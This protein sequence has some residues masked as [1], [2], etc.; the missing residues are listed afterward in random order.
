M[1]RKGKTVAPL[2]DGP[3]GKIMDLLGLFIGG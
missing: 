1:E 2:I 3:D